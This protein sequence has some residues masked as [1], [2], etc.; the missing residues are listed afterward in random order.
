MAQR[1]TLLKLILFLGDIFLFYGALF[2]A[3]AVRHGGFSFLGGGELS[4]LLSHFSFIL[5]VWLLLL[6]VFDFYEGYFLENSQEFFRNGIG[7]LVFALGSGIAYFYFIPSAGIAP[8]TI[9]IL[10]VIFFGLF[11]FWWRFGLGALF[12]REID[13]I[14]NQGIESFYI[15]PE[16]VDEASFRRTREGAGKVSEALKLG[17]D[18]FFGLLGLILLALLFPVLALAIKASSPGPIFY[19][20][21]RVGKDGR[22]F[23]IY[24][25]RTMVVDAERE[26]PRW[27]TEQDERVTAVGRAL[28]LTHLDELPQAINLL[29]GEISLV[30]PRPE[31]PEFVALLEKEIP[32]Y[33]L[34]HLVKPGIFGLAQLNFP[35][36]SSVEDAREKLKYDLYYVKNRSFFLDCVIVLKS[37]KIIVFA[38]GR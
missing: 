37:L 5:P 19:S 33:N 9:L 20:Q 31:R 29:R 16:E 34:R 17:M 7:F 24:K 36:G 2:F 14:Q 3:L 10:D 26:G 27:A 30:G 12:P 4:R 15:T 28:R 8:K 1:R 18:I 35:Y 21:K 11:T 6:Y 22:T 13:M 25:F 32:H 38:K 23:T